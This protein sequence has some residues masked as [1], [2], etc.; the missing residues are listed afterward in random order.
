MPDS[1]SAQPQPECA[2][3]PNKGLLR[4][5]GCRPES[6][7][8]FCSRE[9]MKLIWPGHKGIC[10]K[11][12]SAV[13]FPP[14]TEDEQAFLRANEDR[15]VWG[16]FPKDRV[17]LLQLDLISRLGE[18]DS[19]IAEPDRSRLIAFCRR[20]HLRSLSPTDPAF[21][22]PWRCVADDHLQLTDQKLLVIE[23]HEDNLAAPSYN[24]FKDLSAVYH[25]LLILD[26]LLTR[27]RVGSA[28]QPAGM[29][30]VMFKL[31]LER[32]LETIKTSSIKPAQ[33]LGLRASFEKMLDIPV[34]AAMVACR[35]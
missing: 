9:C 19:G 20:H 14:L 27:R 28:F 22:D 26:T 23:P 18:A 10:G 29:K 30:R 6:T 2:V 15:P 13:Y 25:Q 5:T 34:K 12:P 1:D 11:D 32:F 35:E 3:C 31:A 21:A 8:R 33:S 7:Q 17:P 24:P 4:C 16:V